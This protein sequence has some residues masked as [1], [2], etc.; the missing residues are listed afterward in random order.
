[1]SGTQCDY[2]LR[3]DKPDS[4]EVEDTKHMNE[5][6]MHEALGALYT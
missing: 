3:C 6:E 2:K 4:G 1:M 5:Q